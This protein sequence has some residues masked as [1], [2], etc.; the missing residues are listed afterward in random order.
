MTGARAIADSREGSKP[1]L[2]AGAACALAATG[3]LMLTDEARWLRLGIVAALWAALLGAFLATKYRKSAEHA[4]GSVADAQHI[5]EL[6]LEREI[7]ARR[8]Y[9]LE[10]EAST[11]RRVEQET[12][13]EIQ[14]LRTEVMALR[15]SL[16]QLL[17]GDVVYERVALTE[18]STRRRSMRE[19][20][21]GVASGEGG[22]GPR[23]VSGTTTA[24][25]EVA[26]QRT[27]VISRVVTSSAPRSRRARPPV[28]DES[29][30][31]PYPQQAA[32]YDAFPAEPAPDL[33]DSAPPAEPVQ[34][35]YYRA[36]LPTGSQPDDELALPEHQSASEFSLADYTNGSGNGSG[37][38]RKYEFPAFSFF[39]DDDAQ[40]PFEAFGATGAAQD[41]ADNG[42]GNNGYGGHAA[43]G[44]SFADNGHGANGRHQPPQLP[45]RPHNDGSDTGD[46]SALIAE[47]EPRAGR[48][49]ARRAN[50]AAD[51]G[52]PGGQGAHH[53]ARGGHGGHHAAHADNVSPLAAHA[54]WPGNSAADHGDQSGQGGHHA[55][56]HAGQRSQAQPQQSEQ[57]HSWFTPASPVAQQGNGHA[58]GA[59]RESDPAHNQ[60]LPPGALEIQRQGRPGGRRRKPDAED[61]AMAPAGP[62]EPVV[63]ET[64]TVRAVS[65]GQD[66][67]SFPGAPGP[68]AN[69][70]YGAHGTPGVNGMNGVNGRHVGDQ[71]VS[72]PYP[73]YG[74]GQRS[75]PWP[76]AADEE[77]SGSHANGRSVHDLLAAHGRSTP[78]RRHRYKD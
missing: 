67:Y 38:A 11:R 30:Y 54:R 26:D 69:G 42:Y 24:H 52:D 44:A 73:S 78:T 16:Q 22:S 20:Q 17:E 43:A 28:V 4:L 18:Q 13:S 41:A 32:V 5:Y 8:E 7:T 27:Q 53:A 9:E 50:H 76:R 64:P 55:A 71:Q 77:A 40:E 21:N 60:S 45:R 15:D 25:E 61:A 46:L 23:L 74:A 39:D 6:E 47:N 66:D 3:A 70:V 19:E 34:A 33:Y 51:H 68:G 14:G 31:E 12:Y 2:I 75:E 65:S 58:G 36:E 57:E 1:W 35:R 72:A 37:D 62:G 59:Q 49:A 10:L 56:A 48:R 29:Q 63:P